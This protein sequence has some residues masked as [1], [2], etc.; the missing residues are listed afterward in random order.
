MA[1]KG[2]G[3]D[4]K[5]YIDLKQKYLDKGATNEQA[6]AMTLHDMGVVNAGN[7]NFAK[8][9]SGKE[10]LHSA[11]S[12]QYKINAINQS[13]DAALKNPAIEEG[14]LTESALSALHVPGRIAPD[15]AKLKQRLGSINMQTGAAIMGMFKDNEGRIPPPVVEALHDSDMS[16]DDSPEIRRAKIEARRDIPNTMAQWLPGVTSPKQAN[17]PSLIESIRGA[18]PAGQ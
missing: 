8:S 13:F 12:R 5:L 2:A 6:D 18:K 7:P 15:T 14:G 17:A 16:V 9:G 10:D 11:E 4:R 1:A 3:F